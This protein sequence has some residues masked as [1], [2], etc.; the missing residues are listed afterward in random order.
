[1]IS[2][3]VI[4]HLPWEFS[5]GL[6]ELISY[7]MAGKAPMFAPA[8]AEVVTSTEMLQVDGVQAKRYETRPKIVYPE[9][10]NDRSRFVYFVGHNHGFVL[11][12]G[13]QSQEDQILS[14]FKFTN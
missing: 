3:L 4:V 7:Y 10:E 13:T 2:S 9:T 1:M 12:G 6:D 11:V 5:G 8:A 14:T